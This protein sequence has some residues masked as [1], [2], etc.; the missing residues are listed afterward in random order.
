MKLECEINEGYFISPKL[1]A[2]KTKDCAGRKYCAKSRGV[3]SKILKYED[4]E[5]L[6]RGEELELEIEKLYKT[7]EDLN[8]KKTKIKYRLSRNS[9]DIKRE[10]IYD[11]NGDWVDTL[12]VK[13]EE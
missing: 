5:C 6:Y 2:I 1:Y 13:I 3:P 7:I 10:N 9:E 12:P 8:I 11:D 4:F